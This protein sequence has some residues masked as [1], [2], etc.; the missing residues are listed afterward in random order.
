MGANGVAKNHVNETE[1]AVGNAKNEASEGGGGTRFKKQRRHNED[2]VADV[3]SEWD[4]VS[5]GYGSG[6]AEQR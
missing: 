2:Y 4:K 6:T 5:Q 1:K 3:A